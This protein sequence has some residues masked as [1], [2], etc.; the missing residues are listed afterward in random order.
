MTRSAADLYCCIDAL[1][2][3]TTAVSVVPVLPFCSNDNGVLLLLLLLLV[4][5]LVDVA[6]DDDSVVSSHERLSC[7]SVLMTLFVI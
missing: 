3:A 4:F 2:L 6:T 1:L 7:S 5:V